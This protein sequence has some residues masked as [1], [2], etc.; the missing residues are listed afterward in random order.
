MLAQ[1]ARRRLALGGRL[2][3]SNMKVEALRTLRDGGQL[4][5]FGAGNIFRL[6]DEV[7]GVL[8][9]RTSA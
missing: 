5:K 3:I 8:G 4:E 2:Y 6:G 1:E 7:I 9:S